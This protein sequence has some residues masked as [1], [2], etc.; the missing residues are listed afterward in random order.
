M[1]PE[2]LDA[3]LTTAFPV[4]PALN[5]RDRVAT[6]CRSVLMTSTKKR[7]RKHVRRI[8]PT[9][10]AARDEGPRLLPLADKHEDASLGKSSEYY[11]QLAEQLLRT[12]LMRN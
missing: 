7:K 11:I 6:R 5:D 2:I 3:K 9:F 8:P 4:L 12:W 10:P 1:L